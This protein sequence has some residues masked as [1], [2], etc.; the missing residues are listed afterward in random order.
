[1]NDPALIFIVDEAEH[2][3]ITE[4][5]KLHRLLEQSFLSLAK[6]YLSR[7]QILYQLNFLYFAFAHIEKQ[8]AFNYNLFDNY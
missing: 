4:Y 1:M 6:G 8:L 5:G 2:A 7:I 3:K